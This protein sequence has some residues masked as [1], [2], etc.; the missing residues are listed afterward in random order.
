MLLDHGPGRRARARRP[1]PITLPPWRLLARSPAQAQLQPVAERQAGGSGLVWWGTAEAASCQCAHRGGT[2]VCRSGMAESIAPVFDDEVDAGVWDQSGEPLGQGWIRR[3][4]RLEGT[5]CLAVLGDGRRCGT[6]GGHT[7]EWMSCSDRVL[8]QASRLA[9]PNRCNAAPSSPTN[10]P[11]AG[12]DFPARNRSIACTN[13]SAS[14]IPPSGTGCP[15]PAT[16]DARRC[17]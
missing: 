4:G 12:S 8:L 14:S 15:A 11:S 5:E 16:V 6:L 9:H 17:L 13:S 10:C 3:Q 1:P 2:T 7:T